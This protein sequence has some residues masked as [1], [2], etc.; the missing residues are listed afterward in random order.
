MPMF[1]APWS[2]RFI[3]QMVEQMERDQQTAERDTLSRGP[4]KRE[5]ALMCAHGI[6]E[7]AQQLPAFLKGAK[8]K[9][10]RSMAAR[11]RKLAAWVPCDREQLKERLEAAK[12]SQERREARAKAKALKA[13]AERLEKWKQGEGWG[14]FTRLALRLKDGEV[15]TTHGACVD[16]ASA[17]RLWIGW[18]AG[19]DMV[20]RHV[21]PYQVNEQTPD[22][23][24]IGCHTIDRATAEEFVAR[25]GW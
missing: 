22:A 9:L 20:G 16:E 5:R 25:V 6:A 21:G 15:Q 10:D 13:E 19:A 14:G 3:P 8:L 11:L 18:K 1:V 24:R 4:V 23:I 2:D 12:R 17:R 7:T